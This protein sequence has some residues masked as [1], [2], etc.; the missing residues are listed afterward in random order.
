MKYKNL[1]VKI[2]F[3]I[4]IN[5]VFVL[6]AHTI[7]FN[8]GGTDSSINESDNS[9]RINISVQNTDAG[10][11]ANI[12]QV[13]ITIPDSFTIVGVYNAT[14]MN[15]TDST[16]A[17]FSNTSTLLSWTNAASLVVNGS[18][19]KYFWFNASASTPGNYTINISTLNVTG[20]YTTNMTIYVNDTITPKVSIIYPVN[21]TTYTDASINFN[22]TVNDSGVIDTCWYTIDSGAINVTM[23]N[24]TAS[25]FNQTNTTLGNQTYTAKFYCNDSLN[26]LNNSEQITFTINT[27]VVS[28]EE[29]T[30]SNYGSST[31]S[32][33]A[34]T[35]NLI[36]KED[37][38][39]GYNRELGSKQRVK[40][41]TNEGIHYVGI[42]SLTNSKVTINIS[43]TPQQAVFSV[44]DLKKFDTS[45][46]GYYDLTIKLESISN[47]KANLTLQIIEGVTKVSDPISSNTTKGAT[48]ETNTTKT[49]DEGK[50]A[51]QKFWIFFIVGIII[52]VSIIFYLYYSIK[53]KNINKF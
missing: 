22:I 23:G 3:I 7:T 38:E 6:A 53:K 4:L 44:G 11:G 40:I 13:N 14:A 29:T 2:F 37:L 27:T 20:V 49:E 9:F 45:E 12:T 46:D 10:Q 17:V 8:V 51:K 48:N 24:L 50:T 1:F 33:W 36:S 47:A 32:F 19:T 26:H 34:L 31:P 16:D 30:S 41:K 5:L 52:L 15:G 43:S 39:K 42:I 35:T 25:V 18:E 28:A 21:A